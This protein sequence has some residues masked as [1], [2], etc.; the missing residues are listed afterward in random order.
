VREARRIVRRQANAA[1]LALS[2]ATIPAVATPQPLWE[3]GLGVGALAF[4]DYRGAD[5][6]HVY[7]LPV[8]YFTYRG[9]FL[10]AD[11]DGVRGLLIDRDVAELNLS[12]NA[13][14]PVRSGETLARRGMPN[15]RPTAEIGPS[16]DWHLWRS[17]DRRLR[18]DLNLPARTAI[19]V[20]AAPRSIGWT[21]APHL[22]L[23]LL[24]VGGHAGWNLGVLAG[25]LYANRRYDQYFYG[26]APQ[27]AT[28]GRPAYQAPG[29]YA[30][31]QFLLAL[32][33]RYPGYWVGAFARY[34]QLRG[35]AFEPS[36][37]VRSNG[38][39]L[40]GVGIAWMIGQS[41]RRVDV[42][43]DQR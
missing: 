37:L 36:P 39:W 26:V 14:T 34:D 38:Y 10:R 18:L 9:R 35:A 21:F 27:Y 22:N 2:L 16:L 32:S 28:A 12:V 19:T 13:T 43:D 11:R 6:G 30:G 4:A 41:S 25:P 3:F 7:P 40:G 33:K 1:A 31:T 29:G 15:L 42:R 5:S 20:E 8:P 23:D 17:A 24:D